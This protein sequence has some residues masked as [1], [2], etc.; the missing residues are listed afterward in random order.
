MAKR[1]R[2][3]EVLVG[4]EVGGGAE[5]RCTLLTTAMPT[6]ARF[7][8]RPNVSPEEQD[9]LPAYPG[10][11]RGARDTRWRKIASASRQLTDPA[12]CQYKARVSCKACDYLSGWDVGPTNRVLPYDIYRRPSRRQHSCHLPKCTIG[13]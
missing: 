7:H 9:H 4:E 3:S 11:Q 6:P 13:V 12:T 1:R 2:T 8:T 5:F 10:V